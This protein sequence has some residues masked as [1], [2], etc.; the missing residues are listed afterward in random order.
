MIKVQIGPYSENPEAIRS[1]RNKV[2]VEE[3]GVPEA[4]EVDGLDGNCIHILVWD[5]ES[6][7]A[8]GRMTPDGHIGRV[9][10]MKNS[11]GCGV[12]KLVM[13]SLIQYASEQHYERVWLSAQCHAVGFYESLGFVAYGKIFQEAGIAHIKMEKFLSGHLI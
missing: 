12:G 6:S 7:I 13:N 2:F 9:A 3:Q 11:R 4:L 5:R 1:I 10:V 8:T